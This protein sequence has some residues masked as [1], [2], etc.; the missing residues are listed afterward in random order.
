M[1]D[2]CFSIA[3][4]F[5]TH[6]GV[7]KHVTKATPQVLSLQSP[8]VRLFVRLGLCL[9]V[10]HGEV[11]DPQGA[12]FVL[13]GAHDPLA[14]LEDGNHVEGERLAQVPSLRHT[15]R[16]C[17]APKIPC[18]M[19]TCL[20]QQVERAQTLRRELERLERVIAATTLY[21]NGGANL[22]GL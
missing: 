18:A 3:I 7:R 14:M 11:L 6:S 17:N 4:Q 20:C 10:L 5:D 9:F 13:E 2:H 19:T 12:Q 21:K 8:I 16:G 1:L 22:C 15:R